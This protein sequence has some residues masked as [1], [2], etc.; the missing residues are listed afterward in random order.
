L[1][2]ESEQTEQRLREIVARHRVY[3]EIRREQ[4]PLKDHTLQEVGFRLELHGQ[5][6][7]GSHPTPGCALC[8]EVYAGL[9]EIAAW[10]LPKEIRDSSYDLE[11]FDASL[12]YSHPT[13]DP[14]SVQLGID[15]LHRSGFDRPVDAC[16][17][18]CLREM[19]EE[20]RRLGVRRGLAVDM[21][22]LPRSRSASGGQP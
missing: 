22:R 2:V 15:I 19:E 16:E 3:Y 21:D 20:L 10:I 12:H 7:T 8:Q 11:P 18:R 1:A 9:R 14:G 5:H 13:K 4:V 17:L 6:T